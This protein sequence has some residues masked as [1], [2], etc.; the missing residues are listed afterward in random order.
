MI[1]RASK[2][3][4]NRL[5]LNANSYDHASVVSHFLNCL[6]GTSLE[7][8]PV[9]VLSSLPEGLNAD[10]TWSTLTPAALR[11]QIITE[12]ASRFRYTLPTTAFEGDL[13]R[14]RML[15]EVL[16]RGG[17]QLLMRAYEFGDVSKV[18]SNGSTVPEVKPVEVE[19]DASKKKKKST[20]KKAKEQSA[21]PSQLVSFYPEDVLNLMPVV[22]HNTH[23]V[24]LSHRMKNRN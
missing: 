5:L 9:A 17:I 8:H 3:I 22:K 23:K 13:R 16:L 21:A 20:G 18:V 2:H 24:S 10:R 7:S 15:K 1:A 14:V 4:L 6:L 19:V 12:V 11:S